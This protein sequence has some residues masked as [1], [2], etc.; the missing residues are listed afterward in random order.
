MLKVRRKRLKNQ[1]V[2]RYSM[3]RSKTARHLS[4]RRLKNCVNKAV[5]FI[6]Y[7]F[8]LPES[9]NLRFFYVETRF[10]FFLDGLNAASADNLLGTNVKQEPLSDDECHSE[11]GYVYD[12]DNDPFDEEDTF[13]HSNIDHSHYSCRYLSTCSFTIIQFSPFIIFQVI[14]MAVIMNMMTTTSMITLNRKI[15]DARIGNER[16]IQIYQM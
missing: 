13:V 16:I 12:G 10:V 3:M 14:M 7:S 4:R 6:Y 11:D 5:S 2:H 15:M 9:K 8:I 1:A